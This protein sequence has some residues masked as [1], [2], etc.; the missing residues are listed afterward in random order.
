MTIVP[1]ATIGRLGKSRLGT[2]AGRIMMVACT[3]SAL[4]GCGI[5]VHPAELLAA[6]PTP[7]ATTARSYLKLARPGLK[8][9]RKNV[10]TSGVFQTPTFTPGTLFG[11]RAS[12]VLFWHRLYITKKIY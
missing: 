12:T 7:G 3:G 8:P 2:T 6:F 1:S 5:N 9:A 10:I 4:A 11:I